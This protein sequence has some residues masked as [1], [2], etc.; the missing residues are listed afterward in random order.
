[1][2]QKVF[3]DTNIILDLLVSSRSTREVNCILSAVKQNLLE[4]QVSVQ[5]LLDAYYTS[6][7]YGIP[8]DTFRSF[9]SEIRRYV[10]WSTID[11]LNLDWAMD[12]F[13]GDFE[14]DAQYACAYDGCCDYFITRDKLLLRRNT[15]L[16]PMTVIS[17][18]E[19]VARMTEKKD[20]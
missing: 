19:F 2:K 13:T 4:A 11:S 8:F 18:E 1:M 12:N 10:N 7:K 14:D 15:P 20:F 6:E 9:L 5:S 3:L 17:P 16:C